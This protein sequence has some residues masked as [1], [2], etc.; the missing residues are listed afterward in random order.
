VAK[1]VELAEAL[2]LIEDGAQVVDVLSREAY[3]ESHIPGAV[4]IALTELDAQSTAALDRARPVMT[5]CF[6]YQ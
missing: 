3:E 6:D 1:R 2:R 4:H 5:Y